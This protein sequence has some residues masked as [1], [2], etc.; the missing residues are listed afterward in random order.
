MDKDKLSK[1]MVVKIGGSTLGSHDTTFED[2]VHIQRQGRPL[3]IVH[4]GAKVVT[5]WLKRLLPVAFHRLL[6]AAYRRSSST[7]RARE[8][9]DEHRR[10]PGG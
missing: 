3:V 4:G 5:E 7:Q 8:R 10:S 6:T 2:I 9:A 1:V